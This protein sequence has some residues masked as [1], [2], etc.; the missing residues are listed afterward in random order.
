MRFLSSAAAVARRKTDR[1]AGEG[2]GPRPARAEHGHA[3]RDEHERRGHRRPAADAVDQCH[4]DGTHDEQSDAERAAAQQNQQSTNPNPT[5]TNSD[6]VR[7]PN[8]VP[9]WELFDVDTGHAVHVITD[10]TA[11]EAYNQ[12]MSWLRSVGAEDPRTYGER[13]AIRP[14]MLQPGEHNIGGEHTPPTSGSRADNTDPATYNGRWEVLNPAGHVIRHVEGSREDAE[15]ARQQ[16]VHLFPDPSSVTVRP[17]PLQTE[18]RRA[19]QA[20]ADFDAY[21]ESVI[22]PAK[23]RLK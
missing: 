3:E 15:Q 8:G 1:R 4:A 13:F 18:S 23:K 5:I 21:F 22:T 9:V 12:G 11:R 6:Q 17:A 2:D 16:F 19:K 10:H 7:M 20:F 14:K